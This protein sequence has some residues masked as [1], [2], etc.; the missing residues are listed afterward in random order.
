VYVAPIYR[1]IADH[2]DIGIDASQGAREAWRIESGDEAR[3]E[4][5]D[6]ESQPL[7]LSGNL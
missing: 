6:H 7:E 1:R 5:L 4:Q 2:F 3:R